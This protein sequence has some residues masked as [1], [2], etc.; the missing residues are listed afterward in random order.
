MAIL[1]YG[2]VVHGISSV[3]MV[4]EVRS[5]ISVLKRLDSVKKMVIVLAVF[6][7]IVSESKPLVNVRGDYSIPMV[8]AS[9]VMFYFCVFVAEAQGGVLFPLRFNVVLADNV[10][11]A[12]IICG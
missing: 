5:G 8:N 9:S 10:V 11:V 3:L 12:S 2:L 7:V 6:V 4:Y 1:N